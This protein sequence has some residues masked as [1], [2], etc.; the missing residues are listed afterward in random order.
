MPWAAQRAK[1]ARGIGEEGIPGLPLHE[2]TS[3]HDVNGI[4]VSDSPE[5]VPDHK[6]ASFYREPIEV[7]IP[8][9]SLRVKTMSSSCPSSALSGLSAYCRGYG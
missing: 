9:I 1:A 3:F 8:S 2:A 5:P 6:G 4:T 7:T